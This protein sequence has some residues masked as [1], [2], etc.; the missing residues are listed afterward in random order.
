MLLAKICRSRFNPPYLMGVVGFGLFLGHYT[1]YCS[2][3]AL[4]DLD[5]TENPSGEFLLDGRSRNRL[6]SRVAPVATV[7]H[8]K[9]N[10]TPVV[11]ANAMERASTAVADQWSGQRVNPLPT[12]RWAGLSWS[13]SCDAYFL[14]TEPQLFDF[15]W[16]IMCSG[17]FLLIGPSTMVDNFVLVK[18]VV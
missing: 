7:G 4:V 8:A 5:T 10:A 12:G 9:G 18:T 16:H 15:F 1:E 17:E 13:V 6:R 2:L 3:T 14:A 11:I